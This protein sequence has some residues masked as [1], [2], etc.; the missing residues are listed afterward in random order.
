MAMEARFHEAIAEISATAWDTLDADG[1][2]FLSHAFLSLLEERGGICAENGWQPLHMSLWRDS[3]LLAAMPLYVKTHS[4]GEFVFDWSWAEASHRLGQPYYPK[5]L[6]A[7]PLSPVVGPRLLTQADLTLRPQ[8][9]QILVS[10]VDEHG[11]SSAHVNF[12]DSQEH[13]DLE[14]VGL[15]KRSDWQFHWQNHG[16]ASF[17]DFLDRL[18]SKKRKNIRQERNRTIRDGWRFECLS[19]VDAS[20][21]DWENIF[22]FYTQ[23]F[24][25]KGNWDLLNREFFLGLG[26]IMPESCVIVRAHHGGKVAA[27]ALLLRS[28][29]TLYGRYWGC[30]Q[31]SPGVHF[32]TCYYQGIEYAIEHGLSCFDPGAQG[33]HKIARGFLPRETHS[34]HYLR[35]PTL[36]N[37]VRQSLLRE[38]EYHLARGDELEL[39][40]PFRKR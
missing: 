14:S 30:S 21:Q 33:E 4:H 36:R 19:G 24:Q 1:N 15:I 20:E 38:H 27:G 31:Q 6:A 37:A 7:V 11:F 23:T 32:E 9:A 29:T 35:D 17:Q 39:H 40:S 3:E 12:V 8:M 5:L 16:Y 25:R 10:M 2:P 28:S 26:E 13:S 18:S 22:H 34:F